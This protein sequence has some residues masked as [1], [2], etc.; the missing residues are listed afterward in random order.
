MCK[1]RS[2]CM[3]Q[4]ARSYGGTKLC[5]DHKLVVVCIN[6][7]KRFR[8]YSKQTVSKR[9]IDCNHLASCKVT[10]NAF[11][12]DVTEALQE[13]TTGLD[14]NSV[15]EKT[16]STIHKCA[17][18]VVGY[19]EPNQRCHRTNDKTVVELS[20]LRKKLRVELE[21]YNQDSSKNRELKNL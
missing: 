15:L 19:R 11:K 13:I 18:K 10:Q 4:N 5:S 9:K 12:S 7:Q 1:R 14:P 16:I 17:E 20:A 21:S 8:L 2:K 6:S 3:L